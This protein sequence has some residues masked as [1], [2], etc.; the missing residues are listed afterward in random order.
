MIRRFLML[1]AALLALC[2]LVWQWLR[3]YDGKQAAPTSHQIQHADLR[4]DHSD[5]WVVITLKQ[6]ETQQPLP[7]SSW[8]VNAQGERMRPTDMRRINDDGTWEMRFW[9]SAEQLHPAAHL[10]LDGEILRVKASG[11][12]RMEHGASR[13]FQHLNW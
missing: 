9:L 5:F 3:P 4:C 10:E 7:Q 11:L 12:A 1:M 13:Q 2:F 6:R 8:W